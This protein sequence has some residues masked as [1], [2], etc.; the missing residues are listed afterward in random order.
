M[1]GI[2][3][4][5]LT[6]PLTSGGDDENGGSRDGGGGGDTHASAPSMVGLPAHKVLYH[7]TEVGKVAIVRQL[8][9]HL[10][11]DGRFVRP[12][13]C[14]CYNLL[15]AYARVVPRFAPSP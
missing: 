8:K 1:A 9:P 14:R 5:P 15:S 7:S 6:A 2:V 4:S 10:H 3:A 12:M 11:L 13:I